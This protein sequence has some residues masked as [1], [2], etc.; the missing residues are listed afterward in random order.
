MT[1][2]DR[3]KRLIGTLT[4]RT[5]DGAVRWSRPDGE[6]VRR[7]ELPRRMT[8]LS[9]NRGGTGYGGAA[10]LGGGADDYDTFQTVQILAD[11]GAAR[12][13]TWWVDGGMA[14]DI[15][16]VRVSRT[17]AD[18]GDADGGDWETVFEADAEDAGDDPDFR[19][20]AD[21]FDAARRST[22]GWDGM[23]DELEAAL[24]A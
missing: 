14:P 8:G 18:G 7:A 16:G 15:A 21:L 17:A 11:G 3:T 12:W 24:A 10:G 5:R 1:I 6:H 2:D 4:Q 19:L 13:T 22:S 23:I 9:G 20:L